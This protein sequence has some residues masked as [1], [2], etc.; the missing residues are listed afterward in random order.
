MTRTWNLV[1]LVALAVVVSGALALGRL[2]ASSP[3]ASDGSCEGPLAARHGASS[4]G[5]LAHT[6]AARAN[7]ELS[8]WIRTLVG[9]IYFWPPTC[10]VSPLESPLE[11]R[12]CQAQMLMAR[13]V[14]RDVGVKL[15]PA[16]TAIDELATAHVVL[17]LDFHAWPE[18]QRACWA[19][20]RELR[21]RSDWA[22]ESEAV[23]LEA[24]PLSMQPV[25]DALADESSFS[26]ALRAALAGVWPWPLSGYGAWEPRVDEMRPRLLAGGLSEDEGGVGPLVPQMEDQNRVPT[27]CIE[28]MH[29]GD[30]WFHEVNRNA[31]AVIDGELRRP[32]G[33]RRIL[34]LYG[35]FHVIEPHEGL[36]ATLR[37]L[38]W[39]VRVVVLAESYLEV[40]CALRFGLAARTA[41]VRLDKSTFR[42]PMIPTSAWEQRADRVASRLA[43]EV[44]AP[45]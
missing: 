9:T 5:T 20:L 19:L 39:T 3:H 16:S 26:A 44:E 42:L 27:A 30:R 17:V 29:R 45:R 41:A 40:A 12:C 34:A 23:L 36:S 24:A 6:G 21:G 38:G 2:P 10:G 43:R 14:M 35:A 18:V 1:L 31:V 7:A 37:R 33:A 15:V 25:L 22:A 4:D 13:G 32:G 8:N 11:T 28:T